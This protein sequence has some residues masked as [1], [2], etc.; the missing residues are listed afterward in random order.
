MMRPA[1]PRTGKQ[2]PIAA[3]CSAVLARSPTKGTSLSSGLGAPP[4]WNR[5]VAC[6]FGI[7]SGRW[8]RTV[9]RMVQ[10]PSISPRSIA[11]KMF[12]VD[13]KPATT[14]NFMPSSALSA[15]GQVC[16]PAP[17]RSSRPRAH[18]RRDPRPSCTFAADPVK[19]DADRRLRRRCADPIEP[20]RVEARAARTH[21]RSKRRPGR[22]DRH[23]RAVLGRDIVMLIGGDEAAGARHV[24]RHDVRP[25]GQMLANVAGDHPAPEVE[26]A[27]GSGGDDHGHGLVGRVGAC[28]LEAPSPTRENG[29]QQQLN[30]ITPCPAYRTKPAARTADRD[31]S[32][33]ARMAP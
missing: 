20:G 33:K 30:H 13:G 1:E 21:D 22:H 19:G 2:Q 8:P 3:F 16:G 31:R 9:S 27:A 7:Q 29:R 11:R 32:R 5:I 28:A 6:S 24:L 4:P 18:A 14:L 26:A 23:R 25:A 10:M 17:G 12:A 15:F